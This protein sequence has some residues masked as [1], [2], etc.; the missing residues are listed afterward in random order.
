M[1]RGAWWAT[2]HGVTESRT[3]QRE[4]HHHHPEGEQGVVLKP[5][6]G[7]AAEQAPLKRR[8]HAET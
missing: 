7:R 8:I 2:V 3:R 4:H 6:R 5:K 1:D